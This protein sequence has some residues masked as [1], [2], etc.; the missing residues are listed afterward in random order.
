MRNGSAP[1]GGTVTGT[2][3]DNAQP[4]KPLAGAPVQICP[5]GGGQCRAVTLTG[6]TGRYQAAGLPEG[7]YTVTASA[8]AGSTLSRSTAGPVTVTAGTT[9]TQDVVLSGPI[10]P[11][12]TTTLSPSS[13][14]GQG[15]PQHQLAQPH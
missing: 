9:A 3:T 13:T 11:P 1:V 12:G 8:P 7:D 4:P 5:A 14:N 6:A 10:G 15:I 2:V